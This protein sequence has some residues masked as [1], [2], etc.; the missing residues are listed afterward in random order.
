MRAL[1]LLTSLVVAVACDGG[2]TGGDPGPVNPGPPGPVVRPSLA[3]TYVP[4]GRAAAG[5]VSVQVFEWSWADVARECELHLGPMGYRA[6]LVSPPQ[7]HITGPTWWTRYQPVSYSIAQSRG[8]TR[9]QFIDMVTR[10]RAVGVDIY[11]DAV[12]NHMTATQGTGTNGTVFT[13]YSYPPLYAAADFHPACG[14]NDYGV[15]AQVQDCELVGLADLS[16]GTPSV[17]AKIASYLVEL[18][19][20]GVAGFRIDA[21]KHIQPVQLDSIITRMNR[22][23]VN[24]GRPRPYLFLEVIDMGGEGVPASAYL[25]LGHYSGGASDISEFKYRGIG[26]KFLSIGTQKVSDLATFSQGAWGLLPSDKALVFVQNHDTERSGGLRWP[27]HDRARLANVFMLAEPYGYPMIMSGYSFDAASQAGRD[28]GPPAGN[29]TAAGQSCASDIATAPV[30]TWLCQH[31]DP[32][33]AQMIRFRE[34]VA[35]LPRHLNW[36]DGQQAVAFSRGAM[37]F[38]AIN[39]GTSAIAPNITTGLPAGTYCDL[40]TGGEVSGVCVGTSHVVAANGSLDLTIPARGAVVL[41]VRD[42]P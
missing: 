12:I 40:L 27:D 20:L 38:V 21:A 32:W 19:T 41:L 35:G 42:Q 29:G 24:D 18:A 11:V 26:D 5:H 22:A 28:A 36:N 33:L 8:G 4:T 9:A 37:G 17:Q 34:A 2:P 10:C 1:A 31:R 16:T 15:P 39:N 3:P 7:E 30:G 13:K 14:I 25:G 6:A 23:L